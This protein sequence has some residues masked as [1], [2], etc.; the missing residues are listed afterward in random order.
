MDTIDN[1]NKNNRQSRPKGKLQIA[2]GGE[3]YDIWME[4]LRTEKV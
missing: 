2:E 3:I 4:R 1:N